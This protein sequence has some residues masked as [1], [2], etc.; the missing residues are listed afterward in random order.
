MRRSFLGQIIGASN[1]I[2]KNPVFIEG[3]FVTGGLWRY[4]SPISRFLT[5]N[6]FIDQNNYEC[7]GNNFDL[8]F[9]TKNLNE[10]SRMVVRVWKIDVVNKTDLIS[11]ETNYLILQDIMK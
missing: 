4:L 3:Y 9:S 7:F 11:Y 2:E 6:C 5:Q 1:V 8:H 10:W